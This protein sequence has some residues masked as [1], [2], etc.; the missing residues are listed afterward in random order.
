MKT[1]SWKLNVLL[2]LL[3]LTFGLNGYGQEE[4]VTPPNEEKKEV[5]DTIPPNKFLL[6]LDLLFYFTQREMEKLPDIKLV[7]AAQLNYIVKY[8]DYQLYFRQVIDRMPS[9]YLY[10]NHYVNLSCG[11]NKYKPLPK[12]KAALRLLY[13]EFV[14]IFQNNSARGLQKRF[15]TGIFL[16]PIRYFQPKLSINLGLG[17]IYDWA[18]WEVNNSYRISVLPP[19]LQEKILFINGHTKL[20]KNM[21]HDFSEFRPTLFFL[22]QYQLNDILKLGF[23]VSCQQSVISPYNK[24]I[25]KAYPELA[26]VYPYFYSS[27]EIAVKVYKGFALKTSFLIDYEKNNL[28]HYNS[29]WEYSIM[30]GVSWNY[31]YQKSRK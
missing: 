1:E 12:K 26:K 20:R 28:S 14:F 4:E 9:G 22:L 30:F 11:V 5:K 25:K 15:Q 27:F 29:A 13:P 21:Y 6:G 23:M 3:L 16:Y 2:M 7:S 17:C 8:T 10:L 24:E 18:S 19:K 31:A